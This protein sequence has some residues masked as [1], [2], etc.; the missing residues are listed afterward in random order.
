MTYPTYPLG[1]VNSRTH[2]EAYD[3]LH[4]FD[5]ITQ[6][7]TWVDE[8]RQKLELLYG[9]EPKKGFSGKARGW[10]H[11]AAAIWLWEQYAR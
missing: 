6:F 8:N 9:P 1:R 10:W 11:N 4:T 7:F 3:V 2:A 5:D